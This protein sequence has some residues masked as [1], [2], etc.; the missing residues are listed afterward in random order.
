MRSSSLAGLTPTTTSSRRVAERA[1]PWVVDAAFAAGGLSKA[2]G[3]IYTAMRARGQ[4]SGWAVLGDP[5]ICRL[6]GYAP[7]SDAARRQR[8]ALVA[9]G[10]LVRLD[11][12]RGGGAARYIPTIPTTAILE[13]LELGL[14]ATPDVASGVPVSDTD[15]D[16]TPDTVSGSLPPTP[17]GA[18]TPDT[19]SVVNH[20]KST[21]KST[22]SSAQG[23]AD[24]GDDEDAVGDDDALDQ[25]L[26][27]RIAGA[28]AA[29]SIRNLS[30]YVASALR[31]QGLSTSRVQVERYV[32]AVRA[33]GVS[34]EPARPQSRHDYP[35]NLLAAAHRLGIDPA[36]RRPEVVAA[37]VRSVTGGG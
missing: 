27:A 10:W 22:S 14:I 25:A 26:V 29:R 1:G 31:H 30:G 7:G 17:R 34:Q 35:S 24:D 19:P 20:N 16:R 9:A 3:Q 28:C 2:A 33:Y 12:G 6:C 5:L 11:D 13:A 36:N 32:A 18:P 8:N 23:G 4:N 37:E 21:T 15:T